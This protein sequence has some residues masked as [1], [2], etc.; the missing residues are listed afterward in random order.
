MRVDFSIKVCYDEFMD[1]MF[2]Y[3][4][5]KTLGKGKTGIS[6]LVQKDDGLFV[7]KVM[8]KDVDDYEKQL[9]IFN[10]EK[11]SYERMSKI[12][13]GVPKL[14]EFDE[15]NNY[16]VKEYIEGTCASELAAVGYNKDSGLTD[17]HFELIFDMHRRFK[18]VGIH[19]DYFPANFIFTS[20]DKIYC[21]DY[22]CYDYNQ[23]WDFVEWGIYYW[24][25]EEGMKELLQKGATDKLNKSGTFK[26][27]DE[28]FE[29]IK[30]ELVKK[31]L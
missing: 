18:N 24:L 6:Y 20:D 3:K 11:Y 8:N 21:I 14:Y 13:V 5:V 4:I 12:G 23:E 26:P 19:V 22:E 17:K 25:N 28:P 30:Q 1:T 2:G 10:G 31:F 15:E 29:E 9:E 7:L 27:I 16:L